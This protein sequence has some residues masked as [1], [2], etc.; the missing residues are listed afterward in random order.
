MTKALIGG[1]LLLPLLLAGS[2]IIW[3]GIPDMVADGDAALLEIYT[4]AALKGRQWLGPY[5]RFGFHHPGPIYF[6][7]L[8][9]LY[10]LTDSSSLSLTLTAILLH[11]L[12]LAG[13][14]VI[15][16]RNATRWAFLWFVLLLAFYLKQLGPTLLSIWNPHVPI[17]A[18]LFCVLSFAAV[19]A[20]KI[21]YLPLAVLT[22]SFVGQT[23]I[24]YTLAL[25]AVAGCALLLYGLPAL[26][27]IVGITSSNLGKSRPY[28]A[29]SMIII[30]LLWALPCLE[31]ISH[32]PGNFGNIF[33]FFHQP[34]ERLSWTETFTTAGNI[35]SNYVLAIWPSSRSSG[36]II[37]AQTF[38]PWMIYGLAGGQGILL[39]FS[40]I[41]AKRQKQDYLTALS[42]LCGVLCFALLFSI[43]RV[44]GPIMEYLVLW[45]T[46]A[47]ML[48]WVAIGSVLGQA[49][50]R[51]IHK[52]CGQK[53]RWAVLAVIAGLLVTLTYQNSR[54]LLHETS[55]Q[56]PE[57]KTDPYTNN[58]RHLISSSVD[59][60]QMRRI[61]HCVLRAVDWH[62]W[63]PL[64]GL[65]LKMDKLGMAASVDPQWPA[66]YPARYA[67]ASVSDGMLLFCTPETAAR[68]REVPDTTFVAQTQDFVILWRSLS[69][70]L[71]GEYLFDALPAFTLSYQGFSET[72]YNARQESYRWSSERES[73]LCVPLERGHEYQVTLTI[74]IPQNIPSVEAVLNEHPLTSLDCPREW[75]WQEFRLTLPAEYVRAMNTLSF[76]YRFEHPPET[77]HV[78]HDEDSSVAFRTIV[79]E[80]I[81]D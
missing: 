57:N 6:Y 38:A 80:K 76:R 26:R 70:S 24:G 37:P 9:P 18:C 14:L 2:L 72:E 29:G 30:M 56:L 19:A 12:A 17:L 61:Q 46:G 15:V 81:V 1:L 49:V 28:I 7:L 40:Y 51:K 27:Q 58:L 32:S 33:T 64:A 41:Q 60:L 59:F 39:I 43:N 42:V 53:S 55:R 67:F 16:A 69:I 54:A 45:M 71:E 74:A 31:Q 66:D 68:L 3:H 36:D 75:R 22:A 34:A 62:L 10:W 73:T 50:E 11:L 44:V 8:A 4:R 47:G 79:F 21:T 25:A 65:G 23:H 5:S 63:P 77:Q 35:F 52:R 48:V 20:G 78:T 13:M